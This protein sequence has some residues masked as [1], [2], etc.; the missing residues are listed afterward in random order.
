MEI[1]VRPTYYRCEKRLPFSEQQSWSCKGPYDNYERC[2]KIEF[3]DTN[4]KPT[5][6]VEAY[7]FSMKSY[8]SQVASNLR[9][10]LVDV[11]FIQKKGPLI[12]GSMMDAHV[13]P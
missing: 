13:I 12:T 3:D 2:A 4:G 8:Q 5:L 6:C 1:A 7:N 11:K 9:N 10:M